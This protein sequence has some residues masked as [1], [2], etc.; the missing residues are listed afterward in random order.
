MTY[1][2][3]L[4][5]MPQGVCGLRRPR[6]RSRH[7]RRRSHPRP[8][9]GRHP[10]R[11]RHRPP[12]RRSRP[13]RRRPG[14]HR[15]DPARRRPTPARVP[16]YGPIPAAIARALI[17]AAVGR[18]LVTRHPAPALPPPRSG[19]LVAMESPR[20]A[21]PEGAGP[22]HRPARRHLP[23]PVLRRPDPPPRPRQPDHRGGPPARQRCSGSAKP[24]N[25]PR[26]PRLAV[27]TAV[28]T[29][30]ARARRIHHPHRRR[31]PFHAP[32][33]PATTPARRIASRGRGPRPPL[34]P[35]VACR[36]CI[37][38]YVPSAR[39]PHD[40]KPCPGG[41]KSW[42]VD[43]AGKPI[44][45]RCCRALATVA[46]KGRTSRTRRRS[47]RTTGRA[48]TTTSAR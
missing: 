1:V 8:G 13:G 37:A 32:P 47:R 18:P 36:R 23:H 42:T 26:K 21:V 48:A 17:G 11:T 30:P 6:R 27:G 12:R 35:P 5:P 20:P 22:V 15:R 25:Y 33:L 10:R 16:G 41:G 4:L 43:N 34:A 45:P 14:H 28:A 46:G 7:L 44:C 24:C 3:A 29:K 40:G 2:T 31:P 9:H 19:A 38:A 39:L